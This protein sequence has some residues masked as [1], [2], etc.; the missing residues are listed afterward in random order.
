VLETGYE[1]VR[2]E[3]DYLEED[4]VVLV[5]AKIGVQMAVFVVTVQT[6]NEC[7]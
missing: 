2:Q 1:P 4:V 3:K 7:V 6:E 5:V